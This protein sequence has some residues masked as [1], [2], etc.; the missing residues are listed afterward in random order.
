MCPH[1]LLQ[2]ER[3]HPSDQL[4]GPSLDSLQKVHVF[5]AL[6]APELDAGLQVGSQSGAEGQNS[7]PCPAGHAAVD[8][9]QGM[10]GLLG[11]ENTLVVHVIIMLIWKQ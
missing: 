7:L 11:C 1:S 6:S 9:A 10:V 5:P 3:F 2:G 8:A 4:C